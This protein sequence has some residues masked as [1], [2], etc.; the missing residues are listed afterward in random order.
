MLSNAEP[1]SAGI[2]T[3]LSWGSALFDDSFRN[4]VTWDAGGL[5]SLTALQNVT[6]T[7]R[8][9]VQMWSDRHCPP[10]DNSMENGFE[11]TDPIDTCV[12]YKAFAIDGK[13]EAQIM[14]EFDIDFT[15]SD[16]AR[17]EKLTGLDGRKFFDREQGIRVLLSV[18]AEITV[19]QHWNIFAIVEG[20]PF[21]GKNERALFT[22]LFSGTMPENDYRFYAR[23]GFTY[24]F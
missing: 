14:Q 23:F 24:K 17:A 21:Q 7:G 12:G 3:N 1:F 8:G 4:G 18:I 2:F 22:T 6:I 16:A 13:S 20:T 19:E 15:Q 5:V 11:G 10:L 9:Y